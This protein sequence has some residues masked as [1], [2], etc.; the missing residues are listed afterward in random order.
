MHF[1]VSLFSHGDLSPYDDEMTSWYLD[2][3][4]IAS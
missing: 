4:T 2:I 1:D 3:S